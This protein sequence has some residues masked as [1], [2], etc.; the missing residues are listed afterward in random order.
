MGDT[1]CDLKKSKY[2][3]TRKLQSLCKEFQLEQQVKSYTRIA[4]KTNGKRAME[5]TKG[6]IDHIATYLL[7]YITEAVTL[8]TSFTDYHFVRLH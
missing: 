7:N 4:S 1:I 6:L 2:G 5:T 8:E 3:L